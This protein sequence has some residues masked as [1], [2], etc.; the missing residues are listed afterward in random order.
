MIKL[1]KRLDAIASLIDKDDTVID[2]GCDHALLTIY[3]SIKNNKIYYASDLRETALDM[4]RENIKKYKC[5]NVKLV[6]KNGLDALEISPDIDT[7]VISGMGHYT[8]TKML[9]HIE[10]RIKKVIIQSNTNQ[11]I[12]RKFMVKKGFYIDKEIIVKDKNIYY[13][14]SSFKVGNKKYKKYELEIGV[15]NKNDLSYSYIKDEIK[16]CFLLLEIVPKNEFI[17]RFKIKKRLKFLK[18]FYDK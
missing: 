14:I 16:K 7:I 17:R 6:C 13:I 5:T 10:K 12:I 4:A 15:F 3:L 1:S 9:E 18:K 8:I 11:E 2:I